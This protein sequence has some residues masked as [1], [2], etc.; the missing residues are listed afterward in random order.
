MAGRGHFDKAVYDAICLGMPEQDVIA[1]VPLKHIAPDKGKVRSAPAERRAEA[2]EPRFR[3]SV[4]SEATEDGTMV[5]FD[6][7]TRK[8]AGKVRTWDTDEYMMMVF[9]SPDGKVTG[10]SFYEYIYTNETW[11]E[12]VRRFLRL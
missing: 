1:L 3:N 9:F 12:R 7:A 4:T 5:Y 8:E 6:S 10:K 2:G 11:W